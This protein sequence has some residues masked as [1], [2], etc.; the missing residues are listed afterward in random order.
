MSLKCD[1]DRIREDVS[2]EITIQPND[3]RNGGLRV[4][5]RPVECTCNVTLRRDRATV[6]AVEKQ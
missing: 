5:R 2:N 1:V 4:S 6:V 3:K